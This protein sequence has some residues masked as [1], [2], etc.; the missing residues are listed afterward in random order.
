VRIVADGIAARTTAVP[1]IKPG[2]C[3]SPSATAEA[4]FY[5]RGT[6]DEST[7]YRY[8]LKERKE[9][10]VLEGV[11][12]YALSGD[13]KKLLYR[14]K[15]DWFV[16]EAKAGLKAGEGKL[17]LSSLVV[18]LD[19]VAEWRQMYKAGKPVVLDVA[20]GATG[21]G[22]R[23]VTVRPVA[24]EHGLFYL[25]W[26]RSRMQLVDRLSGGKVGYIHLP[27]TS[28]EGNRMLQKLFY[29]Q[30]GKPA[31]I[32][33]DRY[34]GGG[35]IPDRMIE[36]FTRRTLSYWARRGIE[37]FRGRWVVENEGVSPDIEVVDLPEARIAGGDPSSEEAVEVLLH[38]LAK[39]PTGPVTLPAP[40][41]QGRVD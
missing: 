37:G 30:A 10:K 32:V 9:E 17:D 39:K 7:L 3:R 2:Q 18:K 40:P 4:L 29:A 21:A 38:E 25:D 20:D 1:G 41:K 22:R 12:T 24:S 31:L 13:G 11:A 36:H 6:D 19:P 33:D 35:F 26:V 15:T 16:A 28:S 27:N 34:N 14:V 23:Q 8:D 5:L